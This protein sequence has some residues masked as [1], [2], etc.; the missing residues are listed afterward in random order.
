MNL[1]FVG[2]S[3]LGFRCLQEASSV[4]GVS[5]TGVI[6]NESTFKISYNPAGVNNVQFHDFL[7]WAKE[8]SVPFYRMRENMNEPDLKTFVSQNSVD[9]FLVVGW[10]HMIPKW[11]R[12]VAPAV[13]LHA[14]LLPKFRGG[15]P[16]VWSILE[17]EEKTGISMFYLEDGV[18][19]GDIIEQRETPISPADTIGTI[20]PRI[21]TL[22]LDIVK[23]SIPKLA[24]GT[25]PRLK[26]D[27]E[28]GREYPQRCP[29]DGKI[30]FSWNTRKLHNFIRAQTKPYPGAFAVRAG[31]RIYIWS[32][33][34][35]EVELSKQL[36]TGTVCEIKT[37]DSGVDILVSCDDGKRGIWLTE[38]PNPTSNPIT[39]GERLS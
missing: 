31:E 26:Q 37:C 27:L 39:V 22:A 25:A 20:L 30:D 36:L 3:K 6:S 18:D 13:G 24:N 38:L 4:P 5:I 15:A 32:S 21:E 17:G 14:S 23:N 12:S 33:T 19:T 16:L 28:K 34:H 8:K 7:P 2:A 10:Y 35:S 9:L 11:M 1:I 29:A